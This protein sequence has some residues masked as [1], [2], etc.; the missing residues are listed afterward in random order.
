M[1]SASQPSSRAITDA[2]R[3][4]KHFLPEQRVAAVARAERPD[5][6]RLGEVHDPLLVGVARPR[7][8]RPRPARAARRPSARRARTRR[9][10]PST[11]SAAWPARV[12]VRML[13]ATYGESVIST[14]M[15]ESGEPSG[16]ML[17]GTTYMVRPRI[18]PRNSSSSLARI[19]A[20]AF[21]LLVGP[22]STS[23]GRADEGAVLDP[24][25]VAR[26]GVR[27]VRAGPLRRVE[28]GEGAG[29]DQLLAQELV[30]RVG[31]V[32]PVDGVRLAELDHLVDPRE[33]SGVTG[34]GLHERH[35]AAPPGE[36]GAVPD[37]RLAD[38]PRDRSASPT[39]P[40]RSLRRG[41]VGS[42]LGGGEAHVGLGADAHLGGAAVGVEVED[43]RWPWRSIRKIEP[44]SASAAK[45]RARRGRRRARRCPRP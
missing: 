35:V 11:S 37:G 1:C 6:A 38:Q 27:P 19:S 40:N 23:L 42:D 9:R 34:G 45:A 43:D 20:G 22:A 25:D 10:A 12:I 3:S 39:S 26:V 31:A 7:R 36:S 15:Y 33:Q 2:M 41:D 16:P 28:L 14:P 32:E 24:G 17:N 18:E 4:A 21:Q 30:L 13:T 5:L 8:R 29:V 44:S